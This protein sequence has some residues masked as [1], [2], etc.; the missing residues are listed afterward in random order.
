ML[1]LLIERESLFIS[2]LSDSSKRQ[3]ASFSFWHMKVCNRINFAIRLL[4]SCDCSSHVWW[5]HWFHV[6]VFTRFVYDSHFVW[7]A[8]FEIWQT[9]NQISFK[10]STFRPS[11]LTSHFDNTSIYHRK[12]GKVLPSSKIPCVHLKRLPFW[13]ISDASNNSARAY[14]MCEGEAADVGKGVGVVW[15]Q[16]QEV[17]SD[18]EHN[19]AIVKVKC[20]VIWRG[21]RLSHREEVS[22]DAEKEHSEDSCNLW[23]SLFVD[24]SYLFQDLERLAAEEEDSEA[25]LPLD[26]SDLNTSSTAPLGKSAVFT[27]SPSI[28]CF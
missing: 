4:Q 24:V 21:S 12:L 26:T 11:D 2:T 25:T 9:T 3:D 18:S 13:R 14:G 20:S 1:M 5:R 6:L 28:T 15:C 19:R 22:A 27:T 23:W 17:N 7:Q 16:L 10:Q 8:K